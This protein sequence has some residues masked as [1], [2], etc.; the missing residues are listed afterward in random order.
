MLSLKKDCLVDCFGLNDSFEGI[1]STD[2]PCST[3]WYVRELQTAEGYILNQ[4][5]YPFVFNTRP[6]D[7]PLTWIEINNG[8][9]IVNEVI[10]GCVEILKNL[11]L[12]ENCLRTQ[13]TVCLRNQTIPK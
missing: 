13:N 1:S 2:L 11:I 3:K 7:I 12:T 9:P 4:N 10:K 5:K 8:E 6:Q